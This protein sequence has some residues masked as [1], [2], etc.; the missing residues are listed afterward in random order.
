M[1]NS[2]RKIRQFHHRGEIVPYPRVPGEDEKRRNKTVMGGMRA[3]IG[4]E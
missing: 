1:K 3:A 4:A 2:T